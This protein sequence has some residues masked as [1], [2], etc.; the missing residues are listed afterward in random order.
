MQV[1]IAATLRYLKQAVARL[2]D[3]ALSLGIAD[4]TASANIDRLKRGALAE[5]RRLEQLNPPKS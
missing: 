4:S 2:T 1:Q 3:A 5:I